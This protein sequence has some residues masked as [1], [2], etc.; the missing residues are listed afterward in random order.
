MDFTKY[1][2]RQEQIISGEVPIFQAGD[3]EIRRLFIKALNA[4][5]NYVFDSSIIELMDCPELQ[6][7]WWGDEPEDLED[8]ERCAEMFRQLQREAMEL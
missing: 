4:F 5:N 3:I 8:V 7:L 1:S 6:H 2:K